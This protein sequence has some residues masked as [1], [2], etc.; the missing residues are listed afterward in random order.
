MTLA[1]LVAAVVLATLPMVAYVIFVWWLDRYS[2]EPLWV[3]GAVFAWGACGAIILS[4]VLQLAF[5]VAMEVLADGR[6]SETWLFVA[7]APLTE[8]T[9]KA[10]CLLVVFL[11]RDF[12]NLTDG[13]VY[14]AAAG[15][16]FAM[17]ENFLYSVGAYLS[18]GVAGFVGTVVIRT[19]FSGVMHG[20]AT[21]ITGAALGHVK[22]SGWLARLTLPPLALLGAVGVHAAWNGGLVWAAAAHSGLPALGSFVFLPV[23]L[24]LMLAVTQASLGSESRMIRRE[25][26]EEAAGGRI[27]GEFV[28]AAASYWRRL[29]GGWCPT[30]ID[31]SA[32]LRLLTDLAFRKH[33]WKHGRPPEDAEQEIARLRGEIARMLGK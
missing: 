21:S 24:L 25:L 27:P 8:E 19:L 3:V 20:V 6:N 15:L 5:G 7:V 31:A 26:D 16:G 22:H 12:D 2:R 11:R 32:L 18:S 30:G 17:T 33:Q 23:M 28:D 14:G 13:V 10:V 4:I 1:I 9:F 29:E